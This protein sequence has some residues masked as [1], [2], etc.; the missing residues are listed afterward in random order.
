V[1]TGSSTPRCRAGI[2]TAIGMALR[3]TGPVCEIQFEAS[4]TRL[5]QMCAGGEEALPVARQGTL[6]W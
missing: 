1:T 4:S 2:R 6:R 3:G 5:H